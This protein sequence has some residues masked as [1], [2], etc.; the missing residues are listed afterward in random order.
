[1]LVGTPTRSPTAPTSPLCT[2]AL[3]VVASSRR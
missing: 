3:I 2:T 1:M